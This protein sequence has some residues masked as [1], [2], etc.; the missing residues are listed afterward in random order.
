MCASR[1][2]LRFFR[3]EKASSVNIASPTTPASWGSAEVETIDEDLG[4]SGSGLIERPGFQRLV[5][6]VCEGQV[7]AVFCLEASRLARNGSDWHHLIELC[8]LVGAVLIDPE[9]VYDPRLSNDRLLLGLRGTMSEF[10]LS[11]FR[12]RSVEA[13]R[14]KAQRGELR[15]CLPVGFCWGSTQ[16]H[17]NSTPT[18][19][20]RT[21]SIW[22]FVNSRNSEVHAKCCCWC[23]EEQITLPSIGYGENATNLLEASSVPHD[24]GDSDEPHVCGSLCFR[25]D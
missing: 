9:G 25:T 5:T 4:R 23:R 17:R 18:C 1:L 7:G 15:F 19:G 14:Q 20:C 3:I 2:P 10:E 24:P 13:I 22:C 11:V 21:R 6:E 8:G 16:C 12:Q